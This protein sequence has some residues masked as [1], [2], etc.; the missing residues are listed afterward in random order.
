MLGGRVPPS[1]YNRRPWLSDIFIADSVYGTL[2]HFLASH[3]WKPTAFGEITQQNRQGH[4]RSSEV[5][6]IG[7]DRKPIRDF[8]FY[9]HVATLM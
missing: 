5:T 6:E 7:I 1:P 9:E 8:S 3:T 2:L 4:P